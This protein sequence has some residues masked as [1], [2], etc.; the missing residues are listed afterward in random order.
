M[1]I[2]KDIPGFEG[3]YQANALGQIRSLDRACN[4]RNGKTALRKGRELAPVVKGGRYPAVTLT[5]P[6]SRRQF[7]VHD[8]I[9]LTYLGSKPEGYSTCHADDNKLN[10][11]ISNLR[12]DTHQGNMDDKVKN[13]RTAKGERHGM[14]RLTAAQVLEIRATGKALYDVSASH[15]HAILTRKTWRHI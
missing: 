14:A 8:L 4:A 10:N 7:F 11:S 5:S 3:L 15:K 1:L 6:T 9:A 13:N 2:W 12:Y